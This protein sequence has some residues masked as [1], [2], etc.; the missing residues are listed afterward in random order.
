M[1]AFALVL[2]MEGFTTIAVLCIREITVSENNNDSKSKIAIWVAVIA[3]LFTLTGTIITVIVGPIFEQRMQ[4]KSTQVDDKKREPADLPVPQRS[5]STS[6]KIYKELVAAQ[7]EGLGMLIRNQQGALAQIDNTL[8]DIEEAIKAF[9]ADARFHMLQGYV[10]KDVY[11]SPSAK[12]L[13]PVEEH[14]RYLSL[15]RESAEQAL[16]LDPKS[17][18]A[19]NLMGNVLYFEGD[20]DAAILEY[21]TALRLNR[22]DSFRQVIERDRQ[23]C[24]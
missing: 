11:Q 2:P 6:D 15:A 22:A 17:A 24:Q 9:P 8:T 16:Q 1:Y 23:L 4:S 14:R 18:E 10:L 20:C 13:L 19:H 3:G 7:S 21:D 5:V 12:R